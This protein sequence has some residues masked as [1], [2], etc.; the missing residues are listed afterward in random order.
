MP[1]L[2]PTSRALG[3]VTTIKDLTISGKTI[4]DETLALLTGLTELERL[5]T[6]W[7]PAYR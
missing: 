6:R 1:S 5:S 7:H 3:T 2:R 4:T